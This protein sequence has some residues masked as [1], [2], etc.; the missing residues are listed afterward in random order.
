M[1][2]PRKIRKCQNATRVEGKAIL[3]R[4]NI[5][6]RHRTEWFAPDVG[7]L[8]S[9]AKSEHESQKEHIIT[10]DQIRV[11]IQQCTHLASGSKR[12]SLRID[13]R[14]KLSKF[15]FISKPSILN[16]SK[17]ES[18]DSF[19]WRTVSQYGCTTTYSQI[20]TNSIIPV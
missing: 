15:S 9:Y 2:Q 20:I 16:F 19:P 1:L 6:A 11:D 10:H 3:A 8:T 17:I 4:E 13:T 5:I 18:I 12:P 7:L 14:E